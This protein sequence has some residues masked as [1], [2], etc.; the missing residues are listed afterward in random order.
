I[1]PVLV[2]GLGL[3]C[4][5]QAQVPQPS[6][7]VKPALKPTPTPVR[8]SNKIANKKEL[9]QKWPAPDVSKA[10]IPD[11]QLEETKAREQFEKAKELFLQGKPAEALPLL[12]EA[13]KLQPKR[14]AIQVL[15]GAVFGSLHQMDDALRAFQKAVEIS[16]KNAVAHAGVCRV[17]ADMD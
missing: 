15:L 3:T 12:R 13:E 1:L 10:E 2:A 9:Q 4:V 11:G 17:L 14:L 16:P 6:S 5:G 8:T 7:S